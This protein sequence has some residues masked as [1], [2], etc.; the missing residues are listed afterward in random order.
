MFTNNARGVLACLALS[1][2]YIATW[3]NGS[4]NETFMASEDIRGRDLKDV[5]QGR[6]LQ[7]YYNSYY[8]TT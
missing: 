7:S 3:S 8:G 5:Y 2:A 6:D 1:L 4:S